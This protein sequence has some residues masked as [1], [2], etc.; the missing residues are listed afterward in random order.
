MKGHWRHRAGRFPKRSTATALALILTL[1]AGAAPA[2]AADKLVIAPPAPWVVPVGMPTDMQGDTAKPSSP[3]AGAAPVRLLLSDEQQDIQPGKITRYQQTIYRL[4]TAQGLPAGAVS[5]AW[6]PA[7]QTATVHK[8]QIHRGGQVIDV[9]ASGQTFTVVRRETNL[10]SAVLDG[11]LTASIQPEGLQAGDVI[12]L[13]VSITTSDP[14]VGHHVEMMGAAWNGAPIAHAHFRAQWP[15]TVPM[16]MQADGGLVLPKVQRKDSLASIEMTMADLQPPVLP[17]GAPP[18]YQI[19]RLLEMTDLPSWDALSGL[20][21]PLFAKAEV[22]PPQSAVLAEIAKIKALSP[23]PKVRAEAALAL[24]QDRVRYVLLSLNDGG[25]VPADADTTWSR[26]FGDCKGKTVLLLALLHG[27]GIEAH[28]VLV[29]TLTGDGLD[30]R[31]PQIRLFDHVLVRAS[32]GGRDYWLDGTRVGDR[33]LDGIETP[34]FRWGLPLMAGSTGTGHAALVAMVPPPSDKPQVDVAI[35]IDARGGIL[36]PAP[37]HIERRL[38]GDVAV[39]TNL[40][41]ASQVGDARDAALRQFWKSTYDFAEPKSF[42]TSFEPIKRELLFV[43]DGTTK[44]DWNDGWYEADHVWVGFKADFSRDAG[45][46]KTAPYAVAYPAAT[47]VTETI[48]LPPDTGTFAVVPGSDVDQTVAGREYHRHARVEGDRFVVEESDRSI[49]QEFP[50]AQAPAA[51]ETL[52]ALAK[53]SVFL[54]RPNDYHGTQAERD[55]V[56]ASDPTTAPELVRK[57]RILLAANRVQESVATL[58]KAIALD[59]KNAEAFGLRAIARMNL[60][61]IAAAKPD[62][63]AGLALNPHDGA[64]LQAQGEYAGRRQDYATAVEAFSALLQNA[65][66]YAPALMGRA[67]AYYYGQHRLD[68]A[69]VDADAALKTMPHNTQL[70]LLRANIMRVKGDLKATAAEADALMTPAPGDVLTLVTA[71]RIYAAAGRRDDAMH[72]LDKALAIQPAAYIYI[73][74]YDIRPKSDLAGRQ[75]DIDAALRLEPASLEGQAAKAHL[76]GEQ[77]NWHD[78]VETLSALVT[79]YPARY[80]LLLRR[81]IAYAKAGDGPAAD[82]DFAEAHA[83]TQGAQPLNN[84]CWTKAIAGVGLNR[85]LAECNAALVLSPGALDIQDSRALVL[86]RL[87]RVDEALEAYN[88]ILAKA[89]TQAGSLYGRAVAEERKGNAA[90]AARD[91]AAALKANPGEEEA[92]ASYGMALQTKVG[93]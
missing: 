63:D 15:A 89:P 86:L 66:D 25:L 6:D 46:D 90:A 68:L 75:S 41:L 57:A 32:I 11:Q 52:R 53:K 76:Q 22:L 92:F 42:T 44:M 40:A 3:E 35:T 88:M 79:R 29:G 80:D 91:A 84:L 81:G 93:G 50:A 8:L 69:L 65:P 34:D 21:T 74:R 54:R 37:I 4:Q 2:R 82:K 58:D 24:V 5:F 60:Q 61:Q 33:S 45:A 73:N 78:A 56:L 72:A 13:A 31:L 27:L 18:R 1:A 51:E 49:A 23:D 67:Q 26:R 83:H 28:A 70:H 59:A 47:H 77:G 10:E 19:G 38:R 71:S 48:L 62:L 36:V 30:Q 9:L 87:G 85:A 39:G 64:V 14:A 17:K 16:R 12:D 43:M 55:A 7:T 20:M